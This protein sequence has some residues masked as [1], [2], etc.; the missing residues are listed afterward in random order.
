[1]SMMSLGLMILKTDWNFMVQGLTRSSNLGL[2]G[3]FIN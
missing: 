2:V 3:F 1:M